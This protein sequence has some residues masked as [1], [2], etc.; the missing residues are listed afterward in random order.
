GDMTQVMER[1]AST[2]EGSP[3]DG[4]RQVDDRGE[5]WSARDLMPL[6]GYDRWERVPEVIERAKAAAINAGQGGDGGFSRTLEKGIGRP[7]ANYRL[8]RY[9]CYLVAMNGDPRKPEIAAAQTYFAVTTCVGEQ[10]QQQIP[11]TYAEALRAAA[12]KEE[13]RLEEVRKREI[14]ERVAEELAPR[15]VSASGSEETHGGQ[16]VWELRHTLS[17]LLGFPM[18]QTYYYLADMGVFTVTFLSA[19][20]KNPSYV[21]NPEWRDLLFCTEVYHPKLGR[22]V[23]DGAPR[24]RPGK[25]NEF[26]NR[27]R[28]EF[29]SKVS[30]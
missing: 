28:Q 20:R 30:A 7:R 6:L 1:P 27:V 13:Q 29:K 19:G 22:Y 10:L 25:Q 26:V 23:A 14:A 12:D 9:A 5:F 8:T 18:Q 3:F 24:I 2:P 21:I 15:A 17:R 11:Q 16:S 4:I